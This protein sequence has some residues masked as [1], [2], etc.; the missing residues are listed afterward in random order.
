MYIHDLRPGGACLVK[1]IYRPGQRAPTT[2]G[3]D[4]L[5]GRPPARHGGRLRPEST[6]PAKAGSVCLSVWSQ[7]AVGG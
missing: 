7:T 2:T 6:P 1:V 4:N 5:P 3:K